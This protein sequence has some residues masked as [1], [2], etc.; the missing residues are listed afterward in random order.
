MERRKNKLINSLKTIWLILKAIFW[1]FFIVFSLGFGI[2]F[3]D[4]EELEYDYEE[5]GL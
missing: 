1:V 2:V 3:L 4:S 5:D